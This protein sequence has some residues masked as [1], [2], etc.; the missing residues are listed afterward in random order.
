M[1]ADANPGPANLSRRSP[2]KAETLRWRM[3]A[4]A[5]KKGVM[6]DA[7]CR[8]AAALQKSRKSRAIVIMWPTIKTTQHANPAIRGKRKPGR[9][10][11]K[12][13]APYHGKKSPAPGAKRV[14]RIIFNPPRIGWA[15]T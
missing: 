4:M 2:A 9:R 15:G 3:L 14:G 1:R 7:A 5:E 6:K 11:V 10:R 8:R 13:N 12:D